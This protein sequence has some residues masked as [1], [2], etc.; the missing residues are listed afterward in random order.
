MYDAMTQ[1]NK[2]HAV[3]QIQ[4]MKTYAPITLL[5]VII[6]V[7]TIIGGIYLLRADKMTLA[8]ATFIVGG[9]LAALWYLSAHL[10]AEWDKALVLRLGRFS[11]VRGPGVN[12]FSSNHGTARDEILNKQEWVEADILVGNDVWIGTSKGLG[13]GIG[14]GY[15]PGLKTSGGGR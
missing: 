1:L 11:S 7:G 3:R 15:Y 10:L 8:V 14:E 9:I 6:V 4:R 2:D 5:T 13:W 12:I